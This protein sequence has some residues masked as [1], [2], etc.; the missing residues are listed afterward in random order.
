[1]YIDT[2]VTKLNNTCVLK[3]MNT[4]S[5]KIYFTEIISILWG[6]ALDENKCPKC[7]IVFPTTEELAQHAKIHEEDIEEERAQN[8]D[9]YPQ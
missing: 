2:T 8:L 7:G 1:M 9:F 4:L 5:Q 3:Y 6:I